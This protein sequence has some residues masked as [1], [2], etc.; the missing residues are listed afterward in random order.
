MA[1]YQIQSWTNDCAICI[2]NALK[3]ETANDDPGK[4]HTS[5]LA[6]LN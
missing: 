3:G 5:N 6:F 1:M 2:P 4:Q